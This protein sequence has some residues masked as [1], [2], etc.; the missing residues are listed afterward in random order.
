ML[1]I[2]RSARSLAAARAAPLPSRATCI[3]TRLYIPVQRGSEP[4]TWPSVTDPPPAS[5]SRRSASDEAKGEWGLDADT[6]GPT[7]MQIAL[8]EVTLAHA[9]ALR[10]TARCGCNAAVA[11]RLSA[12][13]LAGTPSSPSSRQITQERQSRRHTAAAECPLPYRRPAS[14]ASRSL[15]RHSFMQSLYCRVA[16]PDRG[17]KTRV[18][19]RHETTQACG[20]RQDARIVLPRERGPCTRADP[21]P[22]RT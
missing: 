18:S 4:K 3:N 1:L 13:V 19:T 11:L 14:L 20:A 10:R 8:H 5:R 22:T 6:A 7:F 9:G 15:S 17:R 21:S 12:A 2:P 16:P